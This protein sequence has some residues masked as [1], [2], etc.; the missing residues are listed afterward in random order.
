MQ[1]IEFYYDFGSPKSYFVHK[2]LPVIAQKYHIQIIQKPI[3]LGGI[4]KLS[5]NKS[6]IE[7]FAEVKGKLAYDRQETERFVARHELPYRPNPYFP[8]MTISLM[9][10]AIYAIDQDWQ[11][12][13]TQV[14]F[15]AIWV[16]AKKMDDPNVMEQV[17]AEAHLPAK[18]IMAATQTPTIKSALI[19]ATNDAVARNVFGAPTLFIGDEMFFGKEGLADID[20]FLSQN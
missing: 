13:Y 18:Q 9:R 8:I 14:I 7:A 17:L 3:L 2:L 16:D 4:F 15:D 11:E 20:Y 5:N 12:D 19:E 10:G 6:P 1:M